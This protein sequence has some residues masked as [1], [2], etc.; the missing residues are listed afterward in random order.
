M[1]DQLSRFAERK[2][3]TCEGEPATEPV[4]GDS[5]LARLLQG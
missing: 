5:G 1:G 3:F 4:R 2:G